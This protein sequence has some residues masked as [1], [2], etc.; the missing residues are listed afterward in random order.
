MPSHTR[1]AASADRSPSG[2]T[3]DALASLTEVQRAEAMERYAVLRPHLESGVPL[4]RAA[5]MAKVPVRSA[6]RWLARYQHK[7]LAGLVRPVRR[8]AGQSRLHP[9]LVALIEGLALQRP[10]KTATRI[11]REAGAM[12]RK[13][14]WPVPSYSGVHGILSRLDPAM[15]TLAQDGE[16]AYRN[17]YE[18]MHRYRAAAPNT[19][20]Q[21][22]HTML[23]VV[24]LDAKDKLVRPW[25]TVVLDDHSRVVA[26]LMVF[27][28]APSALNTALALR[29]AIWRKSDPAW[30]VCGIP[31]T[32]YVDHGA[33]FTSS[34]VAQVCTDLKVRLVHS[35]VARPQG[36]GKVERLFGTINTELLATLPGHTCEGQ[37]QTPPALTLTELDRVITAF[38]TDT[39]HTRIHSETG[40]TPLAAWQGKGFLP[41]MP[42]SL[43][44]LDLLLVMHATPRRVRRDGIAFEGL[45]F[46]A[47]ILS[48]FVREEVTVRYD[49]RDLSEIRVFHRGRF[50]CRA[51]SLEHA[52]SS[53]TLKDIQAARREH[54]QALREGIRERVASIPELL[55][56]PE[57]PPPVPRTRTRL[58]LYRDEDDPT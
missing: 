27:C 45:R 20:W 2:H 35:A 8:D 42:E 39:Y 9:E 44:E 5:A 41:R 17:Q 58:R 37:P 49:P 6:Q 11:H 13:Q 28:G 38:I 4:A 19:L 40:E 51:V 55:P 16:A 48:A 22:D 46:T 1:P 3:S 34:H 23:D 56:R 52:G 10:R 54:R 21:A 15:V 50:L 26:G 47:P 7:G 12:A 18:L 36:R 24:V 31:E 57:P 14:G 43:E 25:L 29:Q 32:L 53:V 30:P 33:D